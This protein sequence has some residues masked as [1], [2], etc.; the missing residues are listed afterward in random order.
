[1]LEALISRARRRYLVNTAL[2]FLAL[3]A[4]IVLGVL[5]LLLLVGTRFL[6]ARTLLTVAI[7]CAAGTVYRL[8][9]G[10]PDAYKTAVSLD[11][12]AGLKDA[13]STAL[14]FTSENSDF[15]VAQ[16]REAESV[17]ASV[18][19]QQAVPFT[20]PKELYAMAALALLSSV[21][22]GVRYYST[23]GLDLKPPL[24]EVL[25]EDLALTKQAKKQAASDLTEKRR[26]ETA[27]SLLAKLGVPLAPDD[28][29]Q[30]GE[31]DKALDQA[32]ESPT[33]PAAD[34]G[35]KGQ[36]DK[37]GGAAPQT[38]A[39]DPLDDQPQNGADQK[40]A[41]KTQDGKNSAG[42]KGNSK[43]GAGENSS[44]MSKLKDAVSNMFSKSNQS[45]AAG[46]KGQQQQQAKGGKSEK[47][48]GEKGKGS[49]GQDPGQNQS[50]AQDGEPDGDA[51]PGQEAQGKAG[52]KS[53][54]QSSQ[55]GS[56]VGSQDGAK[57]LRAA[58][59]LKAMGKISEII[60]KR[61]AT[62]TGETTIEVQSG[63]QQLRTA[64]S[65]KAASHGEADSDVSRDRI[66]VALQSYVQQYFEQ[67][68]KAG[69]APAKTKPAEKTA[70]P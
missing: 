14:H 15:A 58:E 23:H 41:G 11:R 12:N 68:R 34:K 10:A 44:L 19:L 24:T 57:D 52:A 55:A 59:Q 51:Q 1:M 49:K 66:P 2:R 37:A 31:L 13:L 42:E 47:G 8:I 67:V 35:Q 27:E 53:S 63:N 65:S 3:D 60:G 4:A 38:P 39:G 9:G 25:F 46:Q 18:D 48:A 22:V 16:R 6:D 32:L 61:A 20:L 33:A 70:T 56:G 7:L 17:A 50:E 5:T 43:P 54:Q 29:K 21:L 62:V 30:G 40:D 69:A 28:R 36:A 64:Y 26:L 45:D